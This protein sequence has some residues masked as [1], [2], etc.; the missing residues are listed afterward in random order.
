MLPLTKLVFIALYLFRHI[1]KCFGRENNFPRA[2]IP[3]FRKVFFLRGIFSPL[4]FR[5]I[6]E[7]GA[8]LVSAGRT[9]NN[10][11]EEKLKDSLNLTAL[12]PI[13]ADIF[14]FLAES[15]SERQ[16]QHGSFFAAPTG[17]GRWRTEMI[18]LSPWL[19]SAEG[20]TKPRYK[21][22]SRGPI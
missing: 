17:L 8:P 12:W 2:I 9:R 18:L 1:E 14:E 16:S 7:A 5:L 20:G 6:I 3:P 15:S 22:I 4:P 10:K 11:Q 21:E 13:V 19:I